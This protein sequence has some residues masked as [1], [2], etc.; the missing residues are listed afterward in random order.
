MLQR[1]LATPPSDLRLQIDALAAVGS[2]AYWADDAPAAGAAYEQRL[3]LAEQTGDPVLRADAHYDLGFI[4]MLA[5]DPDGLREHE[6]KALELYT[7]AGARDGIPKARQ[8]LVL[9]CS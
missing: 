9:G 6:S 2:L 7:E 8:A 4:S 3:A 5:S 1:L